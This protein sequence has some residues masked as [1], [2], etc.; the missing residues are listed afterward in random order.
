MSKYI[1]NDAHLSVGMG[2]SQSEISDELGDLWVRNG[3]T[4]ISDEPWPGLPFVQT[5]FVTDGPAK[6]KVR[7]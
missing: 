3:N 5:Y 1:R 4:N 7:K 6:T 2:E